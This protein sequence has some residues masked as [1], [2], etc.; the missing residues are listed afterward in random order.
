MSKILLN[1][2]FQVAQRKSFLF[3]L[4]ILLQLSVTA[5]PFVRVNSGTKS[6]ITRISMINENEGYFMADKLFSLKSGVE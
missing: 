2:A 3:L 4:A 6:D 1:I 5:Q